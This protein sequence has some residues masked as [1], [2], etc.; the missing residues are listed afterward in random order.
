MTRLPLFALSLVAC[1]G[2]GDFEA[3]GPA[4]SDCGDTAPVID[5]LVVEQGDGMGDY[6]SVRIT[7]NVSDADFDLHW[8]MMRVWYSEDETESADMVGEYLEIAGDAGDALCN[9]QAAALR[10]QIGVTGNPPDDT[11][12][13]WTTVVYDDQ[14]NPSEPVTSFFRTPAD[15]R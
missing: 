5:E 13:W 3:P 4:N 11:D 9:T 12:M 10:M 15:A 14:E 6:N 7:A 8:Y 2:G 1:A